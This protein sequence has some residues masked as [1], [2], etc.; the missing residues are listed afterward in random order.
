MFEVNYK[1]ILVY[2]L[3]NAN[4]PIYQTTENN[5]TLESF[6]LSF[7]ICNEMMTRKETIDH[8]VCKVNTLSRHC[9]GMSKIDN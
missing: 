8:T 9:T 1:I 2:V 4:T 6:I 7:N 3:T 5:I